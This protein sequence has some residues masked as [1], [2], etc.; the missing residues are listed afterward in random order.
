MWLFF[1]PKFRRNISL[2][3]SDCVLRLL[4]TPN[5]VPSSPI[6][7]TLMMEAIRS[8]ETSVLTTATRRHIPEDD[9][10]HSRRCGNLKS[11]IA[12]T[13]WAL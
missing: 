2:P 13:G 4:V 8:S 5:A 9:I 11:Y 7:V 1:E 10:L 3:S 6:P 12:L